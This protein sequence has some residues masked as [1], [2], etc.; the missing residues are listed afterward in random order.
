MDP[1]NLDQSTIN[2]LN[3]I[4]GGSNGTQSLFDIDKLIAAL[5]P[6]LIIMTISTLVITVL[7][8]LHL[9]QKWRVNHAILEIRDM[10]REMSGHS[11]QPPEKSA[12]QQPATPSE[13]QTPSSEQS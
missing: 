13:P 11:K 8:A 6:F 12:S 2:Q 1:S 5:M 4:L 7:Y 9:Y 3:E 10:V